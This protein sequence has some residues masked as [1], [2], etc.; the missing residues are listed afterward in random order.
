MGTDSVSKINS[1]AISTTELQDSRISTVN[2]LLSSRNVDELITDKNRV[3]KAIDLA[4]NARL[5]LDPFFDPKELSDI[6]KDLLADSI[7]SKFGNRENITAVKPIYEIAIPKNS[8]QSRSA[9]YF[10][11]E[12]YSIRYLLATVLSEKFSFLDS[13]YGGKLEIFQL[14]NGDLYRS[15]RRH[16]QKLQNSILL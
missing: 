8:F 14:D 1:S 6:K 13:V 10:S 4:V 3:L 7:I 15:N 2:F 9:D 5:N 16:F 12:D 11:L